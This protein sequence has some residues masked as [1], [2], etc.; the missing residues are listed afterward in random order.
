MP[1]NKGKGGKNVRRGK[2]EGEETKRQVGSRA[3]VGRFERARAARGRCCTVIASQAHP[4][5]IRSR[6][7]VMSFQ[8]E[9][10]EPGQGE[11]AARAPNVIVW[12]CRMTPHYSCVDSRT[13][14][15]AR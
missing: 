15:F 7:R 8:L 10:K 13:D 6:S 12:S 3:R 11:A 2:N 5:L 14:R 4:V 9:F 1:K